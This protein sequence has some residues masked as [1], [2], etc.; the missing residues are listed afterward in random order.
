MLHPTVS[1]TM[2]SDVFQSPKNSLCD[3]GIKSV[4]EYIKELRRK[5][6]KNAYV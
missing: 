2:T 4:D 1:N 3:N 6:E 5:L